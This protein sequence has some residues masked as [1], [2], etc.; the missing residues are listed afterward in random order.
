MIVDTGVT[1]AT[2][3]QPTIDWKCR[4]TCDGKRY[5]HACPEEHGVDLRVHGTGDGVKKPANGLG[6]G[7]QRLDGL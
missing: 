3:D 5:H 6:L 4:E 2:G 1:F 7:A